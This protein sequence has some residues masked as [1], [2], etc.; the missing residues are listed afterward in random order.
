[1]FNNFPA[2]FNLL[3]DICLRFAVINVHGKKQQ[4]QT[5]KKITVENYS[6]NHQAPIQ[7]VTNITTT[8]YDSK[9]KTTEDPIKKESL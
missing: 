7:E 4:Q 3:K 8:K 1:M 6:I 9:K 2:Q 5:K